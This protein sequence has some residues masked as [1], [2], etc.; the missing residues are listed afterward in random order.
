MAKA[1]NFTTDDLGTMIKKG[2]DG[3]DKRLDGVDKRLDKLEV[4]QKSLKRDMEEIKLKFAYTAWQI[5][6]E[7]LKKR[8]AKV[9]QKIGIKK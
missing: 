9:E 6:L 2:F 3:V 1:K 4:G 7:E 8:V 5:D